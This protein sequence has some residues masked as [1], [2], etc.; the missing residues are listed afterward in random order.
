MTL[1]ALAALNLAVARAAPWD[2]VVFPTLWVLLGT[3]DFVVFWKLILRRSLQAF[4]YTCLIVFVTAFLVMAN[5]V[6]TERFHTLSPLVRWYQQLP[7]RGTDRILI[8]AGGFLQNGEFWMAGF[9]SL[10]LSL[11]IGWVAAWLERR[12]GC[13]LAAFFRGALLGFVVANLLAMI[14]GALWGW[15]VESR[16]RLIGRLVLL[17]VCLLLGG[18]TGLSRL[19]SNTPGREVQGVEGQASSEQAAAADVRHG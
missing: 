10:T 17:G 18:M 9:L 3:I 4:H 8:S 19:K 13:D 7:G 15:V 5:L 14:D 12:R 6:A 1:V 16:S 2:I 11:S